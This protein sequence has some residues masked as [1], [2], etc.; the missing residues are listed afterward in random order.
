LDVLSD[1]TR[2]RIVLSLPKGGCLTCGEAATPCEDLAK[3]TL[4]NHFR[5][6]REAGLVRTKKDGVLQVE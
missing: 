3:S 4:S 6:L 2:L 5:I 1:P